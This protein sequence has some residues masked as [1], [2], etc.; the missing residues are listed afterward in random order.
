MGSS[1]RSSGGGF[2]GTWSGATAYSA[3]ETV[4]YGNATYSAATASTNQAPVTVTNA[5]SGTPADVSVA[6]AND[7]ELG[8]R[9]TVS[10][11]LRM[12][13]STF[14]KS[15]RH[16]QVPHTQKLWDIGISVTTPIASATKTTEAGGDTGVCAAPMV[17]DLQPGR[18]YYNT[19]AT[20]TGTD[21]GY[22][23]TTSVSLPVTVGS[24]TIDALFFGTTIGDVTTITT[25]TTNFWTSARWEEPNSTY[26][27]LISRFDPIAVSATRALTVPAP[28][29]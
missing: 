10:K 1:G 22:C 3:G 8:Y 26:W 29:S 13:H 2:R 11:V 17:I 28:L 24:M 14:Y 7:Y 12:T 5:F 19:V 16:L 18:T 21:T 23:R 20:G 4:V 9:F 25:G 15:A 27:T 6:D